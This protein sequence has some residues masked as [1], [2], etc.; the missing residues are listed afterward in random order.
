MERQRPARASR[1][2]ALGDL[3]FR[4]SSSLMPLESSQWFHFL[5]RVATRTHDCTAGM[6]R[7]LLMLRLIIDGGLSCVRVWQL[8]VE[9]CVSLFYVNDAGSTGSRGCTV[10]V[11]MGEGGGGSNAMAMND[12]PRCI[13]ACFWR[14]PG[15]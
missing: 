7:E 13:A 4:G 11:V 5:R 9:P 6:W 2:P 1:A 10:T 15:M 14:G 12:A 3:S 8:T